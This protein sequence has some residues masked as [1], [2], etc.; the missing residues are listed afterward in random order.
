VGQAGGVIFGVTSWYHAAVF[1]S[2][3]ALKNVLEVLMVD[4]AFSAELTRVI[5]ILAATLKQ[6]KKIL[7]A[8]NGGSAAEADHFAAE[9]VGRYMR[10]R[11]G[12]PAIALSTSAASVTAIGNDY[13][14]TEI[15]ARQVEAFGTTGDVFVGFSTS[16]NSENIIRAVE[17]SKQYGMFTV[18]ILGR[19]GG[20]LKS[21][22]DATL[23]VPAD[24][25]ARIQEMHLLVIHTICESVEKTF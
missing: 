4:K 20:K 21:M 9:I 22:A 17:Q 13:G 14:F 18:C 16:G 15:F 11:R 7:I 6:G 24:D 25:T 3:A 19:D 10:E 5:D 12:Y 23:I 2:F 8:G 1:T